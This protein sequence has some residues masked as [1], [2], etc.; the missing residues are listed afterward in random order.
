[1]KNIIIFIII[2]LIVLYGIYNLYKFFIK[3][4]SSCSCGDKKSSEKASCGG[5]CHCGHEKK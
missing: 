5:N 1:M 3:G 4:E 2:G